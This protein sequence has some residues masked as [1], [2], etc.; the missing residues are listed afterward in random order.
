MG[1]GSLRPTPEGFL[2]QVVVSSLPPCSLSLLRRGAETG[3]VP[4]PSPVP[5]LPGKMGLLVPIAAHVAPLQ[6]SSCRWCICV[7]SCN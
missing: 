1:S 5:S 4:A 3:A 2:S 7:F 6:L